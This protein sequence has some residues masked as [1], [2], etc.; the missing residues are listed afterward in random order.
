M[1]SKTSLKHLEIPVND[2]HKKHSINAG[3]KITIPARI[4]KAPTPDLSSF[5]HPVT[6]L[7]E[8]LIIP[9]TMGT[10][11]L[12]ANFNALEYKLSPEE[13]TTCCNV[14][15]PIKVAELNSRMVL[16]NLWTVEHI[17]FNLILEEKD[18]IKD[19]P[20]SMFIKGIMKFS[21]MKSINSPATMIN[22]L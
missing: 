11:P 5:I 6:V 22:A 14:N 21:D 3:K 19:I 2:I 7:K 20:K 18:A 1:N 10:H 16:K 15:M 17:A 12:I 13:A 4:P 9:P 8:S